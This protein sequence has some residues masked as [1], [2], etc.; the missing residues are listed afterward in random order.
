VVRGQYTNS[1]RYPWVATAIWGWRFEIGL[2]AIGFTTLEIVVAM[3]GLGAVISIGVAI[4]LAVTRP[5]LQAELTKRLTANRELRVMTNA[6]LR[7][8]IVGRNGKVPKIVKTAPLPIG[9]RY[10]ASLP[11]GLHVEALEDRSQE[12]AAALH[13]REVR[14]LSIPQSAGYAEI[15]VIRKEAFNR[16]P[17]SSPLMTGR[18]YS[19]WEPIPLGLVEDGREMVMQLAEHNLLIGGEPGSGKSV[20]LSSIV[21][22]VAL[23]PTTTLT[24]FDGKQVE[25]SLWKDIADDFVGPD[26]DDALV[27]LERLQQIMD[28]RYQVLLAMGR[29]KFEPQDIEGLHVVVIDELAFYLRGGKK[30]V[31]DRFSEALRD[32]ISRG[33]AAGIIVVAATQKPSH[34]VVPTWIRDLFSYRIA[35]RC[36]ASDASDTILGQGW[37]ARGYSAAS[38][39]PGLRGV[40]FVLAEGGVPI[41][42]KAAYLSDSDLR[43]LAIEAR[44][45]RG[46]TE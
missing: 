27:V 44:E 39:D 40:G 25:L 2:T 37:A 9:R 12:L 10:L 26:L 42:F 33:R 4:A 6:L 8:Q 15:V 24:L 22:A 19:L 38:I 14:I 20:V 35:M 18:A 34:D 36:T 29:R 31:R 5:N 28:F 3:G 13:A 41:K 1:T 32:L 46:L 11:A 16:G 7:C 21:A 30:D 45:L 43:L 23:D 17:I